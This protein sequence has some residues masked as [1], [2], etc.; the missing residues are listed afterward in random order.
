MAEFYAFVLE[1]ILVGNTWRKGLVFAIMVWLANAFIVLP[2]IG[3][4]IAGSR[5]L[6]IAGMS[7]FAVAHTLFFVLLSLIYEQLK[8]L[9]QK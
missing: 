3:E 1:P 5:H 9:P 7:F 8:N 6:N 2:L 4:G